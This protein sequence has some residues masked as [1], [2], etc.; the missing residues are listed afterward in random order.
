MPDPEND[1]TIETFEKGYK[2]SFRKDLMS[3]LN[4]KPEDEKWYDNK[5]IFEVRIPLGRET[6]EKIMYLHLM[7]QDL[8]RGII[9]LKPGTIASLKDYLAVQMNTQELI[10]Y[11][12]TCDTEEIGIDPEDLQKI[13]EKLSN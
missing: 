12:K 11:L 10:E 9:G 8:I 5:T 3:L 13:I 1:P 7:N 6:R 4:K 2:S